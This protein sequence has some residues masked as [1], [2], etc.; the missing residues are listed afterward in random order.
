VP[1]S[2]SDSARSIVQR[3][4]GA[5][6][7]ALYAGGCVRDRLMG[8]EPHDYDIA[9]DAHGG[10]RIRISGEDA[11]IAGAAA[12]DD[13]AFDVEEVEV[14]DIERAFIR[15]QGAALDVAANDNG[16]GRSIGANASGGVSPI[17]AH[18]TPEQK[19][20]AESVVGKKQAGAAGGAGGGSNLGAEIS[21]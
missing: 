12:P 3:L 1:I 21:S 19:E 5:G 9:T 2:L 8:A 11:S 18:E 10:L 20:L 16:A 17:A 7:T 13:T 4:Q 14:H 15:L 6:F